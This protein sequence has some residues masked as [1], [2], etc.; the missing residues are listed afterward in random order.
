MSYLS[1]IITRHQVFLEGLKTQFAG[2]FSAVLPKL[3]AGIEEVLNTLKTQS[4]SS[5]TKRELN[6]LLRDLRGAQVD[7]V[8]KNETAFHKKMKEFAGYESGFEARALTSTIGEALKRLSLV[9]PSAEQA[10]TKA[11]ESPLSATGTLLDPFVSSWGEKHIEGVNNAVR[12]AWGEGRTVGQLMQQIRGTK[13]LNYKDGLVQA[14]RRQAEAVART[15]VQHVSAASRDATWERNKDVV[16]GYIWV[17]TLDSSTTAVCRSLDQRKFKLGEGPKPPIHI[18][19]RSTTIA[20]L[21]PEFEFLDKGAT[22]SS[23]NGY[24]SAYKNP[25]YAWLKNQP[26]TFQDAVIGPT[27]AKLLRDGGLTAKRFAELNLNR[28]FQPLTLEQMQ[29]LEPEA[30]RKAGITLKGGNG[31]KGGGGPPPPLPLP[32]P[33]P[34]KPKPEPLP[35]PPP[36]PPPPLPKPEPLPLPLP[37]PPAPVL[38]PP[39]VPIPLPLPVQPADGGNLVAPAT[40]R[41]QKLLDALVAKDYAGAQVRATEAYK[42]RRAMT[43]LTTKMYQNSEALQK[44]ADEVL[45]IPEA[46]R[47]PMAAIAGVPTE[48]SGYNPVKFASDKARE[49]FSKFVAADRLPKNVRAQIMSGVREHWK[50]D[51]RRIVMNENSPIRTWVHEMSHAMEAEHPWMNRKASQFLRKRAAG[52]GLKKLKELYPRVNYSDWEVA[53]ED[54]WKLKGGDH[55]M[56]KYYSGAGHTEVISMGMER[57]MLDPVG[58]AKQDP[59][60]FEFILDLLQG[61]KP[62]V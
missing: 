37:P 39:P 5:L 19:C 56:G 57:L 28:S 53:W 52:E 26:P 11:L 58:F 8:V 59:D 27:R 43:Q 35:P 51:L 30:F 61:K 54:S 40:V 45:A 55:Y 50:P 46:Q 32:P 6:Q 14:S 48:T 23:Q 25:Y 60:Y 42:G 17:S 22:R 10:Y 49:F 20:D 47:V 36:P 3:E 18:N 38:P 13:A 4:M 41:R 7:M 16:V 33:P 24:V 2:E 34:P 31:G 9:V 44:I 1:D 62:T 12:L 29:K 15:A 21:G